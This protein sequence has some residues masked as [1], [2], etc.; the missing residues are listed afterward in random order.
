M[1]Q[2]SLAIN[3]IVAIFFVGFLTYTFVARQHLEGRARQFVTEKTIDYARPLVGV[4]EEAMVSPLV[5][6]LLSDDQEAAILQQIA[7]YKQEPSAYI[8]DLTRQKKLPPAPQKW[9]PLLKQVRETKERIRKFYDETLAA[10]ILDLRIFAFSNLCA[11]LIG[12]YL[13]YWSP[14]KNQQSIVGFSFLIFVSV[15]YCSYLYVDGLTFFRILFRAH[16]G[17]L[18]PLVLS[19]VLAGLVLS[20]RR[21]GQT[22]EQNVANDVVPD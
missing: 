11:A 21:S 5:K 17:W 10:L 3:T 15:L 16:L 1:R 2:I 4:V 12:F 20:F 22:K 8:A 14:R 7:L 19:V 13:A 6:R 9:N 18:Y